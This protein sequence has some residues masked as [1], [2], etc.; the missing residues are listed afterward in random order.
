MT[1]QELKE[2]RKNLIKEE[3]TWEEQATK[4][5]QEKERLER[6]NNLNANKYYFLFLAFIL[7]TLGLPISMYTYFISEMNHLLPIIIGAGLLDIL[8][9][10][11]IRMI[12]QN[13][14]NNFAEYNMLTSNE[15]IEKEENLEEEKEKIEKKLEQIEN[16]L[17]EI[18]KKWILTEELENFQK[19]E[20][21]YA[22]I[23][24]HHNLQDDWQNDKPKKLV[25]M[26]EN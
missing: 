17:V 13:I 11:D 6:Y 1:K 5:K 22:N 16:S 14:K 23:H 4:N 12:Q 15:L 24:F 7:S 8:S 10:A 3:K 26:K 2:E 18:K 20:L 25:K 21:I 19:E 9:I